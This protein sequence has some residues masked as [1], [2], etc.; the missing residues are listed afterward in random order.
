[1]ER[2]HLSRGGDDWIIWLGTAFHLATERQ[3]AQEAA[4][5]HSGN[6]ARAFEEHLVRSIK[7]V[8]R[9]LL[10]LRENYENNP[11]AFNFPN[12]T[13]N[14]YL[15]GDIAS[16]VGIA[17]ADGFL[18]LS[19]VDPHLAPVDL[20]DREHFQIHIHVEN[21]ELFIGKPVISRGD[22]K[23][24]IPLTRRIRNKDGSF[25]G[26]ITAIIET[27][28]FTRFYNAINLGSDGAIA[29]IGLTDG[30]SRL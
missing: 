21:D 29:L 24:V 11:A 28:Y 19:S 10:F 15:F 7:E 4:I 9:L 1:M 18:R 25:G 12:S 20:R 30:V 16:R 27:S 14:A 26:V 23:W 22:G 17:G 5:Q 3:I 2:L 13:E 8:D 6:L